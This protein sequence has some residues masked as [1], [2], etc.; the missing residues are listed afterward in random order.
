M[1]VITNIKPASQTVQVKTRPYTQIRAGV[2]CPKP[3]F[4]NSPVNATMIP[5]DTASNVRSSSTFTSHQNIMV[6]VLI[7]SIYFDY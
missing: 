6:I 5:T 4:P 3:Y 1:T 7:I 2:L